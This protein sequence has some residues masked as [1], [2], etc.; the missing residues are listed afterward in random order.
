MCTVN[1]EVFIAEQDFLIFKRIDTFT[2]GSE[3]PPD[4]RTDLK[5]YNKKGAYLFYP[6]YGEVESPN[7]PGIMGYVKQGRYNRITLL[8]KKGTPY[9]KGHD[10]VRDEGF[11]CAK[12]VQVCS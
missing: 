9:L 5:G 4:L 2:R 3:Y 12:K 7:G 6:K 8:V 10:P 1:P 11:I